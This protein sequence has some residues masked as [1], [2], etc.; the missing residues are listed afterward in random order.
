MAQEVPASARKSPQQSRAR[1]TV[2]A[3]VLAE[4]RARHG[5]WFEAQMDEGIERGAALPLREG[6]RASLARMIELQ[7]LDPTL[8]QAVSDA[9][10]PLSPDDFAKFRARTAD[11]LRANADAL[12]PLDPELAAVVVTRATEALVHGLCRDEPEWLAHPAFLDE[13]TQLVVGYLAPRNDG[14]S[15]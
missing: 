15:S 11:Y 6:V 8:H 1:A 14:E 7:T 13:V 3:I 4:L 12:R 10:S 9:P 5:E 2:D